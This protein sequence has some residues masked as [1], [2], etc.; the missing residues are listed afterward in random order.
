[1]AGHRKR[2]ERTGG[3]SFEQYARRWFLIGAALFALSVIVAAG[4]WD[5]HPI[6]AWILGIPG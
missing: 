3:A 1:M 4:L 6:H 2:D 5:R